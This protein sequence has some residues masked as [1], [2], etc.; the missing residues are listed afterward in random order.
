MKSLVD[1]LGQI[2]QSGMSSAEAMSVFGQRAGPGVLAMIGQGAEA[3]V[4]LQTRLEESGGTAQK[5]AEVQMK[6]LNGAMKSF[7]S[8]I[9]GLGLAIASS[10]L[11]EF[12][13]GLV[14][15]FTDWVRVLA[16]TNPEFLN[17]GVIVAG[18]AAAIG[19]LALVLGV[20]VTGLGAML[21]PIGLVVVA[22]A[23]LAAAGVAVPLAIAAFG[24]HR[25]AKSHARKEDANQQYFSQIGTG[26][27]EQLNSVSA[28]RG[29]IEGLKG[30][31][32]QMFITLNEGWQ[33]TIGALEEAGVVTEWQG[34]LYD[35]LGNELVM[36]EGD[37][38]RVKAA[39]S[40]AAAT[41]YEFSGG[42][43]QAIEKGNDLRVNIVGDSEVIKTALN[44]ATAMG[45]VD[46][47]TLKPP[48]RGS[49]QR[50]RAICR[51]GIHSCRSL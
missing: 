49:L 5:I 46:S 33:T 1:I 16:D 22:V 44:A 17:L 12:T 25:L 45:I 32:D 7:T 14:T 4:Q 19:S 10:G 6:G 40:G 23:G 39:L 37:V 42:L 2:E 8:A 43:T 34:A 3:L 28:F 24:A 38:D 51:S 41:G 30:E 47:R 18:A 21:S 26:T 48:P 9:E 27:N 50:S 11:L 35:E 15:Q 20:V 29:A 31:A 36:L 13:T